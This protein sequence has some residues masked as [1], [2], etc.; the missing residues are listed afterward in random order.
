MARVTTV[1]CKVTEPYV[2]RAPCDEFTWYV[3]NIRSGHIVVAT[4][5]EQ[6]AQTILSGIRSQP[7]MYLDPYGICELYRPPEPMV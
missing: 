4:Y 5:S 1:K 2:T 3:Y 7:T 6:M